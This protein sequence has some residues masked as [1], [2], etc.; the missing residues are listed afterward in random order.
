MKIGLTGNIAS[1]KSTASAY[2]IQH[3]FEIV[4]ADREAHLLYAQSPEL[5][6]ELAQIFGS[7]IL[8]TEQGIQRPLLA[9]KVFGHPAELQKLNECI[10]PYLRQRLWQAMEDS[11]AHQGFAILDAALIFENE[12]QSWFEQ[13]VLVDCQAE[14]R[15][16]RAIARGLSE[17]AALERMKHQWSDERKRA[18]ADLILD[19]SQNHEHLYRQMDAWM[20]TLEQIKAGHRSA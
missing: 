17:S 12:L 14:I 11:Q 20:R 3:G 19:N 5:C 18:S 9:Q 16:R 6:Q 1:G 15:L 2:L 7:E 4:D 8:C 13:I 10:R